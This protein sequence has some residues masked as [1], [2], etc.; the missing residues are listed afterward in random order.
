MPPDLSPIMDIK[1]AADRAISF[2]QGMDRDRFLS[3]ERTRWA[4]YSQIVLI[5]EAA[6]RISPDFQR[7][8]AELPWRQMIGMRHRLIHGYDE[9]NWDRVWETVIDDLPRV[10]SLLAPLIPQED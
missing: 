10:S 1:L 3:D 5:G 4:V 6:N 7:E 8:H 2:A 9:I